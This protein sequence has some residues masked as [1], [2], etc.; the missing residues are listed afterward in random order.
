MI[1]FTKTLFPNK[2]TSTGTGVGTA[3]YLSRGDTV[4]PQDLPSVT[5]FTFFYKKERKGTVV[6]FLRDTNLRA[7]T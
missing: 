1:A 3:T 4:D 6:G 7:T 5:P 2:V